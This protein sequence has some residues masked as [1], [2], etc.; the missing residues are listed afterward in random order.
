MSVYR[1]TARFLF[2]ASVAGLL[3]LLLSATGTLAQP[4]DA[5]AGLDR[6]PFAL[7]GLPLGASGAGSLTLEVTIGG[8]ATPFVLDTGAAMVTI[9]RDVFEQLRRAGAVEASRKV[10]AR[11]AD[12]RLRQVSVQR[13]DRLDLGGGC[14]LRDIEALVMP[15]RGRNLLGLN[16]L[17]RFAPFT[18]SMEPPLLELSD[19]AGRFAARE[20]T[21]KG[22]GEDAVWLSQAS[23]AQANR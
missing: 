11:L 22:M 6:D 2:S 8:V 10:A 16:A 7:V 19:C 18:L 3:L 20:A 4:A 23:S 9:S 21:R 5:P 12:G 17:A 15:G 1:D 13:I 14:E